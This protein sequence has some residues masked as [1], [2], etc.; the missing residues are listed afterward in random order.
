M[1]IAS[2]SIDWCKKTLKSIIFKNFKGWLLLIPECSWPIFTP[3]DYIFFQLIEID[4]IN[5][6]KAEKI[7]YLVESMKSCHFILTC[8]TRHFFTKFY[9]TISGCTRCWLL[10]HLVRFPFVS[11]LGINRL[12]NVYTGILLRILRRSFLYVCDE[13]KTVIMATSW[14]WLVSP[15]WPVA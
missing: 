3:S 6:W 2:L 1:R 10:M 5:H 13:E 11:V 12:L 9:W 14:Y 7:S 15:C 8:L 4:K